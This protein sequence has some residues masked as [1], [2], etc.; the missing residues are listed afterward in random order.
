M[1][2]IGDAYMVLH[3]LPERNG[4][5]HVRNITSIALVII[6]HKQNAQLTVRINVHNGPDCT[7][8]VRFNNSLFDDTVNTASRMMCSELHPF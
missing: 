5:E 7:G 8:V 3:D 4:N 1:Q 2:T 6:M